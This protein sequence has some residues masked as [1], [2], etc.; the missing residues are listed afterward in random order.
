M[1]MSE[2]SGFLISSVAWRKQSH[3]DAIHA[4]KRAGFAGV[5][6]LFEKR[7]LD[8][9]NRELV[10]EVTNVLKRWD[11]AK[12]SVHAPFEG[13]DLASTNPALWQASLNTVTSVLEIGSE[14]GVQVMV[15]HTRSLENMGEWS[16]G[17]LA[18][19][20]RSISRLLPLAAASDVKIAVENMPPGCFTS[21]EDDLLDLLEAYPSNV[22]GACLDSGHAFLTDNLFDFAHL[23]ASRTYALHLHDNSGAG[24]DEHLIPGN[25]AIPWEEFTDAL[26]TRGF[27]G[28]PIM[29]VNPS[30]TLE[31][32]LREIQKGIV[33]TG[34]SRLCESPAT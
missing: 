34:L 3:R 18:A 30:G 28:L 33:S 13:I 31:E 5:E 16:S 25:G 2:W 20:E 19:F 17:S 7:S 9:E 14:M 12:I 24:K 21:E 6:M 22:V 10:R 15:L 11:G 32:T 26:V 8:W 1:T 23:L 4:V 27:Q 29:E